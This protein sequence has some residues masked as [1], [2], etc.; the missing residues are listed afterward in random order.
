VLGKWT[1]KNYKA[2]SASASWTVNNTKWQHNREKLLHK[3]FT[4][5]GFLSIMSFSHLL[6]HILHK[7]LHFLWENIFEFLIGKMCGLENIMRMKSL[8][9]YLP[10]L[11]V[12]FMSIRIFHSRL[13][14]LN[15]DPIF[16][17]QNLFKFK[18]IAKNFKFEFLNSSRSKLN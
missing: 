1:G 7:I 11:W 17:I 9:K 15:K 16:F 8:N 12:F 5:I 14:R 18:F 6:D 4:R 10:S 3:I 2:R 13:K